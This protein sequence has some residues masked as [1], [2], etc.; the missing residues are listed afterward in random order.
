MKRQAYM[1]KLLAGTASFL[2]GSS[3][4]VVLSLHNA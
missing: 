3:C 4:A 1:R 2:I